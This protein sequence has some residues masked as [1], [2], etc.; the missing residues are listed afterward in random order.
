M[1]KLFP[2]LLGLF[3]LLIGLSCKKS[4]GGT[5]PTPDPE[6]P[7]SSKFAVTLY[8]PKTTLSVNETFDVKVVLYNVTDVF[9]A[10]VEMGYTAGKVQVNGTTLGAAAFASANVLTVS[11]IEPDSSRVSYGVTYKAGTSSGFTGSG[12]MMTV[13]CKA[14]AAGA[15]SLTINPTKLELNKSDG[16]AI[17]NFSSIIKE[18]LALTIQ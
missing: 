18:N 2:F 9:G 4:D 16:N 11:Q 8:T 6:F 17:S 1:N 3:V 5:G 12:V 14:L 10:A 15:A 13:Q 7:A